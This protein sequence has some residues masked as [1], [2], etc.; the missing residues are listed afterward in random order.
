MYE[1]CSYRAI[2]IALTTIKGSA[3]R[4][5]LHMAF[6]MR[7]GDSNKEQNKEILK[8]LLNTYAINIDLCSHSDG[9]FLNEFP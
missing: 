5:Y 3:F 2:K 6:L 4:I 8:K 1:F 9:D 7:G